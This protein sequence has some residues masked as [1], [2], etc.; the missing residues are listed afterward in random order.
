MDLRDTKFPYCVPLY[1]LS[2][3][4]APASIFVRRRISDP[5]KFL[6]DLATP[7]YLYSQPNSK[8]NIL[9][10]AGNLIFPKNF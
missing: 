10:S 7:S 6:C 4:Y 9:H 3:Y 8:Y 5:G 2:E 1:S